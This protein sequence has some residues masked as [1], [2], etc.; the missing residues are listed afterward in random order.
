[1]KACSVR[2]SQATVGAASQLSVKRRSSRGYGSGNEP[3]HGF[4]SVGRQCFRRLVSQAA[5]LIPGSII[6]GSS[7][8]FVSSIRLL[9]APMRGSQCKTSFADNPHGV[10]HVHGWK[11]SSDAWMSPMLPIA[12]GRISPSFGHRGIN[13]Y[14]YSFAPQFASSSRTSAYHLV[15]NISLSL[16]SKASLSW[17]PG[18][19]IPQRAQIGT[20]SI[21]LVPMC[22][23][24]ILPLLALQP[25]LL[26]GSRIR[27]RGL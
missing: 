16:Y 2:S 21:T 20:L 12:W 15:Y 18:L 13:L 7:S 1:M 6:H 24:S 22:S 17:Q 10:G 27:G 9:G 3:E 14:I 19:Q 8:P 25:L 4:H 26:R 5:L 23:R 11:E